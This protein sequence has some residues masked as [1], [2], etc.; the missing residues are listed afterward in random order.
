MDSGLKIDIDA[1]LSKDTPLDEIADQ[2]I[3]IIDVSDQDFCTGFILI[4]DSILLSGLMDVKWETEEGKVEKGYILSISWALSHKTD[5]DD[6]FHVEHIEGKKLSNWKSV[7]QDQ[8][9]NLYPSLIKK[10]F[11]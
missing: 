2:L 8:I 3:S 11:K 5:F 7:I 6:F 1:E 4:G 10:H 9:R